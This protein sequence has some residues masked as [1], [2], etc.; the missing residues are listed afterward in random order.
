MSAENTVTS[1]IDAMIVGGGIAG[2]WLLNLLHRNGYSAVLLEAASIGCGQ[3]LGSQGMIHG[4]LKYALSGSLTGA[5]EAIAG[6]PERWRSCLAGTGTVDLSGLEPLSDKYYLYAQAG[7][8]GRLTGFFASRMLRGRIQKLAPQKFP[9][10]LD[11]FDGVVYQLNDFV[12][13]TRALLKRLLDPVSHLVYQARV[14]ADDLTRTAEGWKMESTGGPPLLAR[15][16]ILAAG[17]GTAELLQGLDFKSPQMQLRPLHQVV[18]RHPDLRPLFAHCLTGVTRSEPRLT[19]TSHPDPVA[20]AEHWL[21]YLGGRLATAGIELSDIEQQQRA[22]RE[23]IACAPWIEWDKA[24]ITSLRFDRAEPAQRGAS[25][26]DES[27]VEALDDTL[28]C[29]PT[30]LSL[31]PDLGDRVLALMP[32]P[33]V[34]VPGEAEEITLTHPRAELGAAPWDR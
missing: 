16:L 33:A 28:V 23:L 10:A 27:Y 7:S 20:G 5:S 15:R 25:R 21:W 12:L 1:R 13:D 11:A 24:E 3:T 30:K 31:A 26:P 32:P 9:E 34:S 2:T 14:Q 18:A 29:W 19:I 6:M 4:G 22:R 8:L 17:A